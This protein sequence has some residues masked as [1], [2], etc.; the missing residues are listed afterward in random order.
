MSV[1]SVCLP[2]YPITITCI[3]GSYRVTSLTTKD[4]ILSGHLRL[5]VTIGG[6]REVGLKNR[7][8]VGSQQ[9]WEFGP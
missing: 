9:L 3:V 4:G 2:Y 6:R 5:F 1:V 8:E 7:W